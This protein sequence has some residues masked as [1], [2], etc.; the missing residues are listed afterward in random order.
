M[1]AEIACSLHVPHIKVAECMCVCVCVC[2]CLIV[3]LLN[4]VQ[5]RKGS[6]SAGMVA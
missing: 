6:V 5:A 1:S 4:R 2:V 3:P